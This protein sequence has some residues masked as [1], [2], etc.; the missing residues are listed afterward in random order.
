MLESTNHEGIYFAGQL[1]YPCRL[2]APKFFADLELECQG[3]IKVVR[4]AGLTPRLRRLLPARAKGGG[5]A[6]RN[7]DSCLRAQVLRR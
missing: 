2:S 1:L 7:T 6:P 3:D 5:C 4:D